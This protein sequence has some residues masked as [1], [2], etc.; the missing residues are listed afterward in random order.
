MW[1]TESR[2]SRPCPSSTTVEDK[3]EDSFSA[4]LEE[5]ATAAQEWANANAA[6]FDTTKT[7]AIALSR[8]RRI[9]TANARGI[10]VGDKA[11]HFSK[12]ATRWLGV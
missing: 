7:E 4:R 3:D 12:H 5:A 6:S 11:V 8:R 9:N 1:K 10:Q 2:A